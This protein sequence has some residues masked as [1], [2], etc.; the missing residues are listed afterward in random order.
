MAIK[1]VSGQMTEA[2]SG[3]YRYLA[4]ET[5]EDRGYHRLANDTWCL[6]TLI[7]FVIHR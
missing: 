3:T 5:G 2:I 4:Q 6:G 7:H 1:A